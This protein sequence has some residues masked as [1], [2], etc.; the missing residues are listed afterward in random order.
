MKK[1]VFVIGGAA[2]EIT[3]IPKSICR[4]RDSNPGTV[5]LAVGGVARNV[6]AHLAPHGPEVQ[7]V[8]ALGNDVRAAVIEGDCAERGIHLDHT[9]HLETAT[10]AF[11]CLL[12]EDLDLLSGINDMAIMDGLTPEFF[13]A[14]LPELNRGDLCVI[15][16]NLTPESLEYLTHTLTVPIYYEPVSCYK[17][18]RIGDNIGLCYTV[19]P[20]RFEAAQ[21]SGCSCDTV[22]GVYRAAD[23]FLQQGVQQVFISLGSDG[24]VY[25]NH[26]VCGHINAETLAV[27]DTS[28]AGD[29]MSAAIVSAML[30]GHDTADCAAI[31]NHASGIYC[32]APL[33]GST[34]GF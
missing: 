27:V 20:N 4:L 2:L 13:E 22:R 8:T 30:D 9:L 1:R 7:L 10:A 17:A 34:P 16:A 14:L 23:W 5:R 12:D 11:L 6:A 21:L 31:G 15:D 18:R 29:V 25:A 32:A 3:G 19:K 28:G 24:I 26:D 33:A